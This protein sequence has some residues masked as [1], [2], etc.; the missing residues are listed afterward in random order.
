MVDTAIREAVGVFHDQRSLQSAV[1]GLLIAGFDRSYLS[2]LADR[3]SVEAKL[4]H[5][6]ETVSDLEDDTE[7]PTRAFIGIDSLTEGKGVLFGVPFYVGACAAAISVLA[8]GGTL[9]TAFVVAAIAGIA[10]MAIGIALVRV[11]GTRQAQR[12]SEQLERGGLLLWVRTPTPEDE[13]RA[14][15]TMRVN[16]AADVHVHDLPKPHYAQAGGVS[17]DLSFMKSLGM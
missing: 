12:L 1:D 2:M 11:I 10:C 17:R 8:S 13:R 14:I 15:E 7:V 9:V 6:V 16:G 5:T 4:G 3:R